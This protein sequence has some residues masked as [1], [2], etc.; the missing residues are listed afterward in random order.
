MIREVVAVPK[1][2]EFK[3]YGT[4]T[5]DGPLCLWLSSIPVVEGN[6]ESSRRICI[7]W[8]DREHDGPCVHD[9][10]SRGPSTLPRFDRFPANRV[11]LFIRF[12]HFINSCKNLIFWVRLFVIRHIYVYFL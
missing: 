12:L 4:E 1:F 10:P 6:E 2:Q 7:V 8:D 3:C 11:L 9:D 5:L